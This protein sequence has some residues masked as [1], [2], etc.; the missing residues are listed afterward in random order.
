MDQLLAAYPK[1]VRFVYK[2]MPLYQIH[3][4]AMN[5]S[6]AAVAAAKQGKYWDMHD[7]L[8]KNS[9]NLA[10]DQIKKVAEKVG[11]DMTKFEADMNS[12]ETDKFIKDELATAQQ[13]DVNGT[14]TFFINGKRVMNRT[15][16]GMKQMVDDEL[17]KVKGAS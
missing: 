8:F 7:E 13:T 1:D 10:L 16:D 6:K 14:P 2:Q 17:K 3:Q 11:L 9:S 4:N 5:A 15:I 12:P